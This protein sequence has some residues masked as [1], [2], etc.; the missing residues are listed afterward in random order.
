MATEKPK[1]PADT[2][3]KRKIAGRKG[4]AVTPWRWNLGPLRS[5]DKALKEYQQRQQEYFAKKGNKH[6][7]PA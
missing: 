5:G 7:L 2:A 4:A 1:S 3:H 6:D